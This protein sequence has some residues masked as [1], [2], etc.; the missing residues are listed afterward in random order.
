MF[1]YVHLGYVDAHLCL[2]HDTSSESMLPN[3]CRVRSRRTLS[4]RSLGPA[5][6]QRLGPADAGTSEVSSALNASRA[7]QLGMETEG[8]SGRIPA[9]APVGSRAEIVFV[10]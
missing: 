5:L 2:Y 3:E 9:N 1:L 4:S 10:G 7:N 8:K 6:P